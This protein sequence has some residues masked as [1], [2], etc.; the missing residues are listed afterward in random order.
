MSMYNVTGE[1]MSNEDIQKAIDNGYTV[2]FSA[3]EFELQYK[4]GFEYNFGIDIGGHEMTIT[5]I[6]DEGRYIVSTWGEKL[7]LDLEDNSD[8]MRLWGYYAIKI[9]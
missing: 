4:N 9:N 2:V 7:Y 8:D 6:D 1:Q 3:A 5:G